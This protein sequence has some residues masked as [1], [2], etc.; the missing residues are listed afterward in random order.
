MEFFYLLVAAFAL[1]VL[2]LCSIILEK[3]GLNKL[4]TLVLLIPVVNIIM[5]WAFAFVEWPKVRGKQ[6]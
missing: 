1:L 5:L 4:W 2:W 6:P 3:A